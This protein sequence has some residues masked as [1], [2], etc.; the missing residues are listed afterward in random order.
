MKIAVLARA[1]YMSIYMLDTH[2]RE[3]KTEYVL[4]AVNLDNTWK[5]RGNFF[6]LLKIAQAQLLYLSFAT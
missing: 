3:R 4:G 6:P 1:S 2:V 5:L